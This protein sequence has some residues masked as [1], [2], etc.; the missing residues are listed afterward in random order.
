MSPHQVQLVKVNHYYIDLLSQRRVVGQVLHNTR[1]MLQLTGSEI[2]VAINASIGHV[3]ISIP[4]Y[5]SVF[6]QICTIY[7][8]VTFLVVLQVLTELSVDF[9]Q[10]QS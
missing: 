5:L 1:L 4:P 6:P 3:L 10:E 2:M 9:R 7:V 8:W